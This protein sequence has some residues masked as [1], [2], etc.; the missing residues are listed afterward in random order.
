MH[1]PL[2]NTNGVG[3]FNDGVYA[4]GVIMVPINGS[5][6]ISACVSY[7]GPGIVFELVDQSGVVYFSIEMNYVSSLKDSV[8][9]SKIMEL[10]A[11]TQ[12]S[13]RIMAKGAGTI[14]LDNSY[15]TVSFY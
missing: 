11:G 13:P 12:L 2:F 7:I 3:L 8:C 14:L 1:V 9:G 15:I 5:T 4:N 6:F 10:V